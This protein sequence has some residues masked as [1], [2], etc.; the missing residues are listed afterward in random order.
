MEPTSCP[1]LCMDHV[2]IH[3]RIMDQFVLHDEIW[4]AFV[5]IGFRLEF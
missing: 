3:V 4:L 5:D 2:S 1:W